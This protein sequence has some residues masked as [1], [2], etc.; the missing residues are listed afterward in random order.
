[1]NYMKFVKTTAIS[2]RYRKKK[3]AYYLYTKT[4]QEL[5][6]TTYAKL[7]TFTKSRN[8]IMHKN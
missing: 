5:Y 2:T 1:M 4:I 6:D 7:S 3:D 8:S